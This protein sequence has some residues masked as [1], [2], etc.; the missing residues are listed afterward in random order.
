MQSSGGSSFSSIS[1]LNLKISISFEARLLLI[2]VW[3]REIIC[4]K[5]TQKRATGVKDKWGLGVTWRRISCGY[6]QPAKLNIFLCVTGLNYFIG[7]YYWEETTFYHGQTMIVIGPQ[8]VYQ[9]ANQSSC[10]VQFFHFKNH[11]YSPTRPCIKC[12]RHRS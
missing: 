7:F 5:R 6:V 4:E 11:Y 2:L 12:N 10:Y 1:L 3:K 8:E 9:L